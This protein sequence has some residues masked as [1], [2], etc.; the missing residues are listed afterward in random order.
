MLLHRAPR[1]EGGGI[2]YSSASAT[3]RS[4]EPREAARA[5]H[6]HMGCT[7]HRREQLCGRIRYGI[8]DLNG[9]KCNDLLSGRI[10]ELFKDVVIRLP[11]ALQRLGFQYGM[12]CG[13][14]MTHCLL[15]DLDLTLMH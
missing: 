4:V 9:T 12:F 3:R 11:R 7:V 2:L 1:Q 10:H 8:V 13:D 5:M 15:G 14:N 6:A